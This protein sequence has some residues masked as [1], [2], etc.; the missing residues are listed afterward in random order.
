MTAINSFSVTLN[1]SGLLFPDNTGRNVVY[2]LSWRLNLAKERVVTTYTESCAYT[3][4]I[5]QSVSFVGNGPRA[6][7]MHGKLVPMLPVELRD[8][9]PSILPRLA[10]FMHQMD[11]VLPRPQSKG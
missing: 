7:P 4:A 8:M 11:G 3:G 6:L 1:G 10:E 9:Y 2:A 5:L